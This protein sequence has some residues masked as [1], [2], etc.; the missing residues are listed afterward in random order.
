[1]GF[2]PSILHN[3][4]VARLLS[5]EERRRSKV[6]TSKEAAD[7]QEAKSER[8][9]HDQLIAYLHHRGVQE[10]IHSRMDKRTTNRRGLA[11]ICFAFHGVPVA[12]EAKTKEGRVS[13]EQQQCGVRMLK[14]GWRWAIV[15]SLAE[16]KQILD[17]L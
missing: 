10:I 16:A 3:E 14:D 11:D 13:I 15:R 6:M 1:M 12:F 17:S 9:L 8:E 4:N 5:P 7:K 2:D